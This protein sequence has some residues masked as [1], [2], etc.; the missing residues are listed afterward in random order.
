MHAG[1]QNPGFLIMA[2][3]IITDPQ[4]VFNRN[5]QTGEAVIFCTRPVQFKAY[6]FFTEGRPEGFRLLPE[7][8]TEQI[9]RIMKR[10]NDWFRK[11]HMV[12]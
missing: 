12:A 11:W 6:V 1:E 9:R 2:G 7:K 10:M 8:D 5:T 3:I 4:F